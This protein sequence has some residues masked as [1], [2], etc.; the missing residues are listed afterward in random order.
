MLDTQTHSCDASDTASAGGDGQ[1]YWDGNGFTGTLPGSIGFLKT[2]TTVSF[3][4]NNFGGPFPEAFCR[5][6]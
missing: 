1:A 5:E 4:I 6:S 2:L 3:N